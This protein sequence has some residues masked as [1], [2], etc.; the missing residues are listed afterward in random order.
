MFD[1]SA[2][3]DLPLIWG[4]LIATA[5]FLYV[6][7]DG[8]DLGIGIVFP[9]AP[10][11]KCRD[12]MMNSIAP[13]W[14]GN[15]TWLILGGGGL[16]AAFPLAYS[17][18]MPAFYMPI[19][20]MLL[21]LIMRGVAFEFR[22]KAGVKSR[23]LWD[24]VF[25]FGSLAA[26]FCQGIIL[27]G[28]VQ[29]VKVTGNDFTGGAFDWTSGF[30]M[31][32]GIAVVFGYA[33]LGS[34]WLIMKTEDITQSWARKVAAYVL[35]FVGIFMGLVSVTIPFMD[36]RIK[37]FWF[38]VPNIYYLLP[39]PLLTA[40]LF[41]L[42]WVDLHNKKAEYRPFFASIAIFLLGYLGIGLSF[43]P[44]IVPFHFT[45]WDAAASNTGL[46]LMLVGV[47][48]GLPVILGYTAYCYYVFRGKTGHEHMY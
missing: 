44:W 10:S 47:I 42:I 12:R 31:M 41:I 27:G 9:F 22:F 1:L 33:L 11:D 18:L 13:F 48:P 4:G 28:F 14:D 40:L 36:E 6:L 34:T 30:S 21:G 43:Y 38:D 45:F 24:Y 2:Y 39:I 7:L 35:G 16:F 20:M 15:E 37:N 23:K 17:I 25:H 8:F 5:I 32:T 19:I 3:I 26:A 46:S 29:G